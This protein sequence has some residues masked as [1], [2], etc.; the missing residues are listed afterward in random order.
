MPAL[1]TPFGATE[2]EN[3][4][5]GAP[6][7]EAGIA[8]LHDKTGL[9]AM[10]LPAPDDAPNLSAVLHT[11][12]GAVIEVIAPN[13]DHK[14]LNHLGAELSKLRLPELII[15]SVQVRD[16]DIASDL[17][18]QLNHPVEVVQAHHIDVDGFRQSMKVGRMGPGEDMTR[19]F[20]T[21]HD[22]PPVYPVARDPQCLATAL[23]LTHWEV[24][25]LNRLL[26]GLGLGLRATP[27][28]PSLRLDLETPKGPVTLESGAWV[29]GGMG[30][31]MGRVGRHV[32]HMF[33]RK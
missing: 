22:V 23:H 20:L 8:F 7:L 10:P 4:G 18:A 6:T 5:L 31:I 29:K 3:I 14:G 2:F 33:A 11:H 28:A 1:L 17:V 27:G 19:P 12:S 13:P 26:D 9:M 24:P 32:R 15:W 21:C 16:F 25:P 30:Q